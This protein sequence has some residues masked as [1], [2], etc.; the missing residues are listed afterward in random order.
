MG[1]DR[2]Q[3]EDVEKAIAKYDEEQEKAQKDAYYTCFDIMQKF[4]LGKTQAKPSCSPVALMA[5]AHVRRRT[6]AD[7]GAI[8]R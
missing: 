4:G 7:L 8:R 3:E 6:V 1:Y 5:R 2:L